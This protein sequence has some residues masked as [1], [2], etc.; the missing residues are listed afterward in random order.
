[1]QWRKVLQSNDVLIFEKKKS[2]FTIRIEARL[3]EGEWEVIKKY[4]GNVNFSEEYYA[5]TKKETLQ[6][7]TQLKSEKDLQTK[8]IERIK[9][10]RSKNLRIN[11]KRAYKDTSVEKWY[12]Y[13]NN[14]E[15][16]FAIIRYDDQTLIDVV[17]QEKYRYLEDK[18]LDELTKI[19]GLDDVAYEIV[20]NVY[21][22]NKSTNYTTETVKSISLEELDFDEAE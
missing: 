9:K 18:I 3:V 21:F 2:E 1:M 8:D 12:I 4:Y 6:L 22:Y 17:V 19:L 10:L 5:D 16:G 15:S 14:K 11:A 13:I 7:I 20:Q